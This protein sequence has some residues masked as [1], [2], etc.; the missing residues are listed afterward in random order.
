MNNS[1]RRIYFKVGKT[2]RLRTDKNQYR[3][4][5]CIGQRLISTP[6]G[7][8]IKKRRQVKL[9]QLSVKKDMCVDSRWWFE[10]ELSNIEKCLIH[11][12]TL[13]T[14]DDLIA[15]IDNAWIPPIHEV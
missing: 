4:Y 8:G 14:W 1:E 11:P 2:V 13:T 12:D 3:M 6:F 15:S 10:D 7:N 9:Q 5:L